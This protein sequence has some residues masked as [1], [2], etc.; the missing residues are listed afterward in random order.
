MGYFDDRQ[1]VD[2][3][4]KMAKGYDGKELIDI[5]QKYLPAGSSLLELGMGPGVDLDLL[6]QHYTATGSDSSKVFID[7]YGEK[8]PEADLMELDAETIGTDR[9]FN[10]IFSNKVMHHLTRDA[11]HRSFL[12]QREILTPGGLVMH[13]FWYG[14]KEETYDG[15][16]FIYYT[17][18]ELMKTIGS[19][20]ESAMIERYTEMEE[21][22][23]FFVL[24]RK[25]D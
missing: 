14:S 19:G 12:R 1:H 8:D 11:L 21:D 22:D 23:S 5:L 9:S 25:I 2:D 15:L 13:S 6:K 4:I 16:L 10:C 7:L 3:Y 24:L 18:D 20:F 17:E